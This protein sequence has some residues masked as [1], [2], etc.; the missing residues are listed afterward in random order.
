MYAKGG[1]AYGILVRKDSGIKKFED[2]KGKRVAVT[3]GTALAQALS[4]V[5]LSV[6][7][8][9]NA[10]LRVNAT[11]ANMGPMM[12]QGSVDAMV[13]IEPFLTIAQ[14]QMGANGV[15][16]ARMGKFVQGGG[17]FAIGNKWA[18]ANRDKIPK[19]VEAM[20]EAE[21]YVRQNQQESAAI[22]AEFIK[23]EPRVVSIAF[24]Y[25]DFNPIIDTFTQESVVRTIDFLTKEGL[26]P[27]A[28]DP[29]VHLEEALRIGT[30]LTASRPDL[31]K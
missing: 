7:L 11:L 1:D 18:D 29:K 16:L 28:V 17:F 6:G 27:A 26:L 15:L 4:Q 31:L 10:A 3:N 25:Y 19:A 24:G 2:L 12:V 5:L 30:A 14:E 23:A 13:G 21:Q 8:P 9:G 20:W 22:V